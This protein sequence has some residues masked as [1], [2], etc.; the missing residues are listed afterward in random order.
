MATFTIRAEL[1]TMNIRVAVG[2]LFADLLEDRVGV[3]LGAGNF[4]MHASQRISALFVIEFWIRPDRLPTGVGMAVLA[5]NRQGTMRIG[6]LRPRAA[7]LRPRGIG[8][9]VRFEGE[10]H[11]CNKA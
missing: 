4:P 1:P 10:H 3:A 7:Q 2:T 8:L 11:R 6:H 9:L 5:G